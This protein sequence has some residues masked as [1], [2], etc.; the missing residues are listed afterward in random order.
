MTVAEYILRL[1]AL[2]QDAQVFLY[3]LEIMQ[4]KLS[5]GPRMVAVA[6]REVGYN[7]GEPCYAIEDYED[8]ADAR[9]G[10]PFTAVML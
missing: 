1:Q 9:Q 2:P 4:Y 8:G 7:Q 10:I 6:E 5:P 3:D